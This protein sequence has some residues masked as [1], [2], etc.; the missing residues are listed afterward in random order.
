M[1]YTV[2][3]TY[4]REKQKTPLVLCENKGKEVSYKRLTGKNMTNHFFSD[5]ELFASEVEEFRLDPLGF[6]GIDD[7]P[8]LA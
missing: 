5:R 2:K 1:N 8:I 7:G 6:M 3:K 4:T